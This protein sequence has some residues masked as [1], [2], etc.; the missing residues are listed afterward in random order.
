MST[1]ARSA[2][3]TRPARLSV[4]PQATIGS[5]APASRRD[6]S[7][8]RSSTANLR[9]P[10]ASAMASRDWEHPGSIGG[11]RHPY[12]HTSTCAAFRR[13]SRLHLF[14][15]TQQAAADP[16]ATFEV[17]RGRSGLWPLILNEFRRRS[18]S[19]RP[20]SHAAG[21]NSS[22]VKA[23]SPYRRVSMCRNPSGASC[24]LL[25]SQT[26]SA[27]GAIQP[28]SLRRFSAFAPNPLP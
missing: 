11:E 18:L 19:Q 1:Q 7:G 5:D 8:C 22:I 25:S 16:S 14:A 26:I 12:N 27:P 3:A 17:R 15:N 2:K 20:Q 23:V 10:S 21:S 4:R 13:P 24:S 6:G 28:S 9:K